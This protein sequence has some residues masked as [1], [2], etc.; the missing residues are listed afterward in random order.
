MNDFKTK[1]IEFTLDHGI[2]RFGSF[3]LKSG[4]KSPYFFNTGLCNDGKLIHQLSS[5]YCSLIINEKLDFDFIFGP[6][7]KGIPLSTS[8]SVN[9]YNKYKIIKPYSFNRKE[10]K[11]HGEEG[12]F[13]GYPPSG[14][15]LIVDDVVS[16]GQSIVDSIEMLK[17]NNAQCKY[18]LVAFDRMEVGNS[19]RASL[20]LEDSYG[21]KFF[22]IITLDDIADYL[23]KNDSFKKDFKLMQ[24]YMAEYKR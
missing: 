6:A 7:Y 21:I 17:Q 20:E 10:I 3:V 22:S 5:Y 12:E 14:K 1:F 16:S 15:S 19:K 18:V 23:S 11:M 2:L 24:E 13:I 4:R 8:I 9:L